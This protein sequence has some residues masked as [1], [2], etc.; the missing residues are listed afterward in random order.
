MRALRV[1]ILPALAAALLATGCANKRT[2]ALPGGHATVTEKGGDRTIEAE[3][4]DGKTTVEVKRKAVTEAELGVPV[5]PGAVGD[6]SGSYEG[7][8]G[9]SETMKHHM[10]STR[11]DFD[12]VF[13][14]YESKLRNVENTMNQTAGS[15]K[16]AVF[17]LEPKGGV[18][19]SVSITSDKENKVTRIQVITFRKPGK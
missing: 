15:E 12:K 17:T 13:A 6:V 1:L 14:F 2:V 8:A 4:G 7:S 3:T 11:D 5:Y 10:L 18:K 16:I 19:T 9:Q